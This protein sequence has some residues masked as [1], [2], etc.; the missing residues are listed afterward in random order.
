M[1]D[2][3]CI[4]AFAFTCENGMSTLVWCRASNEFIKK[5]HV[6]EL[7]KKSKRSTKGLLK[8]VHIF[9]KIRWKVFQKSHQI[10]E[11]CAYKWAYFPYV[12]NVEI[13]PWKNMTATWQQHDIFW[14]KKTSPGI[15]EGMEKEWK[16]NVKINFKKVD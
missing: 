8:F 16:R 9:T 15:A 5:G 13:D 11:K 1:N 3:A 12:E 6:L 2:K 10:C 14:L 4:K 7:L